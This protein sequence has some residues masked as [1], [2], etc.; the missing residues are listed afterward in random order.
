MG[1]CR[2]NGAV[3]VFEEFQPCRDIG[4]ATGLAG[5]QLECRAALRLPQYSLGRWITLFAK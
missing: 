2:E 1:G 3:V 5:F 4:G